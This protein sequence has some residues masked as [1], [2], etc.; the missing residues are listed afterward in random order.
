MIS[1]SRHSNSLRNANDLIIDGGAVSGGIGG[2][3]SGGI[4]GGVVGVGTVIGG[5][6]G[7]RGGVGPG[8]GNRSHSLPSCGYEKIRIRFGPRLICDHRQFVSEDAPLV[9]VTCQVF[10]HPRLQV[11]DVSWIYKVPGM[12]V[13]EYCVVTTG[14]IKWANQRKLFRA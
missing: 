5:G 12:E 3:G 10:A 2:I 1:P 4:G 14:A 7:G 6:I 11:K 8:V 13:P 9:P